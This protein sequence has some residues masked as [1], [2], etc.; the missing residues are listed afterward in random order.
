MIGHLGTHMKT[1]TGEKPYKCPFCY[2]AFASKKN[3]I[4]H[5]RIHTGERP[6]AC[7]KC[8]KRFYHSSAVKKHLKSHK[9]ADEGSVNG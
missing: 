1:H 5:S 2:K 6:Y 8:D 9:D 7:T 3:M 4:V